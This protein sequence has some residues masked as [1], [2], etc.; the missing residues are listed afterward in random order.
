[1]DITQHFDEQLKLFI[2]VHEAAIDASRLTEGRQCASRIDAWPSWVFS[3]I[4]L[5]G[6]SLRTLI[7]AGLSEPTD[8]YTLDCGAIGTL[9]RTMI[10]GVILCHYM[11]GEDLSGEDKKLRMQVL[12]LH[13]AARRSRFL[14]GIA[15]DQGEDQAA[16]I[17]TELRN[18]IKANPAFQK[19]AA[20]EQMKALSGDAIY[21][22]GLR[23]AAKK[24]GWEKKHF[25]AI[26][27]YLSMQAHIAPMSFHRMDEQIDY[28]K[29]T[30]YQLSFCAI[31]L[32]FARK[33]LAA[34]SLR[35]FGQ[36]P[37]I[38][39]A[40]QMDAMEALLMDYPELAEQLRATRAGALASPEATSTP[41]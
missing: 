13:D 28:I 19:L 6:M 15:A 7:E 4:L 40:M 30:E 33:S 1:M 39:Q 34:C 3:K 24:A 41:N 11:T 17:I 9:A 29:P 5:L 37:D 36:F 12:D 14:K 38:P 8:R 20:D 2:R 16:V 23:A 18:R 35:I 21:L 22:G 27:T 25:D 10:E 32:E 26:Y 31:C